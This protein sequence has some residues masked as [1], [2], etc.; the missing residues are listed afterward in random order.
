[1]DVG[2]SKGT[3]CASDGPSNQFRFGSFW[4]NS[5]PDA[6]LEFPVSGFENEL[7]VIDVGPRIMPAFVPMLGALLQRFI[8]TFFVLF[9]QPLQADVTSDLITE[10]IGLKQEEQPR[11]PAVAVPKG[12]DAEEI[13]VK[14]G[15]GDERMDLAFA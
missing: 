8:V 2:H 11:D 5:L 9:D 6:L 1:M 13:E 10:V 12:M 4:R 7:N 15:Q 3:P 14:G